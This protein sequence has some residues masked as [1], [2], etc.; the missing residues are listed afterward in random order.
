M[1]DQQVTWINNPAEA[2][3]WASSWIQEARKEGPRFPVKMIL[4][5]ASKFKNRFCSNGFWSPGAEK[6]YN[7]FM[8]AADTARKVT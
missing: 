6:V 3:E 8:E 2:R 7:I 5:A 1:D 4:E